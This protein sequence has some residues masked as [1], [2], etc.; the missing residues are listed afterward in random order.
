MSTYLLSIIATACLFFYVTYQ[1]LWRPTRKSNHP[2]GPTKLPVIGNLLQ[3]PKMRQWVK[4]REWALEYGPIYH[5]KAGSDH[6]VVLNA[7]EATEELLV[8][9]NKIFAIVCLC[10]LPP[11]F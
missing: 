8:K 9:K 3:L 10:T 7:P 4:F 11:R 6:L 2:P 1:A 5:L